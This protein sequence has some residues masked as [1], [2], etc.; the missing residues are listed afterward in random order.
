MPAM[1]AELVNTV[2]HLKYKNDLSV[3]T[4]PR[5]HICR[6]VTLCFGRS[7]IDS[8]SYDIC[9][10]PLPSTQHHAPARLSWAFACTMITSTWFT[11]ISEGLVVLTIC[12]DHTLQAPLTV[13]NSVATSVHFSMI[14]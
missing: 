8:G 1:P 10:P 5:H 12:N 2:P 3:L 6:N 7:M 14:V 9:M 13:I 11:Y 4:H